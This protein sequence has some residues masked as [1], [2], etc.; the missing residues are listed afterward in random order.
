ME[1]IKVTIKG[2]AVKIE[3][4]GFAGSACQAATDKLSRALGK[5]VKDTATEEMYLTPVNT[6]SEIGR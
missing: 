6:E 1:S 4:S 2:G 5:S 3:T